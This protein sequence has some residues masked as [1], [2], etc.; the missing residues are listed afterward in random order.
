MEEQDHR[1]AHYMPTTRQAV[2]FMVIL[3]FVVSIMGT[4]LTMGI[5]T[6][7]EGV[8][9]AGSPL[10]FPRPGILDKLTGDKEKTPENEVFER[11]LRQD[12]L[13]VEVVARA[14]PAVVS[15]VASK[16]VPVI[17]QFFIDPFGEDPQ[18]KEFFGEGGSG[19]RIPQFRQKGTTQ[20][21]VSSGTG[22]IVAGDGL[23]LT[24]R[25]VLADTSAA[26]T[27]FMQDGT[28]KAA[29]VVARDPVQDLA[30]LKIEGKNFSYLKLGDSNGLKIGQT[31]IAIGNALGEFNNTVSV[32]VVSGLHRSV[33]ASGSGA[34]A[35]ALQE[36]IQTDAA[37][38]PGN[39]GGPLLN[40]RGEVIGINT[41]VARGAENIGF[42]ILIN[43]AKR[44][45]ES[46]KQYGRIIYPFLGVRYVSVTKSLAEKEKLGR[47]YG[48]W[49]LGEEGDPGVVPGSPAEKAGIRERDIILTLNGKR[50]SDQETLSSLVQVQKIGQEITLRVFR[51][52]KEIEVKVTLSERK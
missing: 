5:L 26:Y 2:I 49:V 13:V 34:K 1:E 9:A 25:H 3:S 24:N 19:L 8:S 40:I 51:D 6:S 30:I 10:S 52:N 12:E 33:I 32:G 35:E 18:L 27:V 31:V 38:N 39:S 44:D 7:R 50:I 16:D 21:E 20:K 46:V 37:I 47:D 36:L 48:V 15:V 23:I 11:I 45:L 14:S 17:E 28:K 41:A 22:F 43:A 29:H 4:I 42:A